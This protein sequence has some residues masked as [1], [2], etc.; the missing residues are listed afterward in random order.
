MS[1]SIQEA[2]RQAGFT[3]RTTELL[4]DYRKPVH[5][6]ANQP[7]VNVSRTDKG[8]GRKLDPSYVAY[9]DI[10]GDIGRFPNMETYMV[11]LNSPGFP[12]KF[13]RSPIKN[14]TRVI[15][16][17]Y[18][19]ESV[20][21]PNYWSLVLL[22]A[23][24]MFEANKELKEILVNSEGPFT[25]YS[26]REVKLPLGGSKKNKEYHMS[27]VR[28]CAVLDLLRDFYNK[29]EMT[30]EELVEACKDKPDEDLWAGAWFVETE[31]T[32]DIS[33]SAETTDTQDTS[34]E[35]VDMSDLELSDN[36]GQDTLDE[37][38][39]LMDNADSDGKE[40]EEVA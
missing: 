7:H 34:D 20:N 1:D 6:S 15:R 5:V 19:I 17:N 30:L 32:E 4:K 33:D 35:C 21:M 38:E 3:G 9:F 25:S 26:Y 14:V 36:E 29:G 23:F 8:D 16:G 28:Y 27:M 24:Y 18:G 13:R 12:I 11:F 31:Q 2:F 22:G 10:P 40:K 37:I 39:D